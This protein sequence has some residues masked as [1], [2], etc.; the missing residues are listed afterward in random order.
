MTMLTVS[1][2]VSSSALTPNPELAAEAVIREL[3]N[4]VRQLRDFGQVDWLTLRI[5]SEP[6]G[7]TAPLSGIIV[8]MTAEGT[9]R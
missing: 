7:G 3:T 4:L 6:V 2:V 1:G 5:E 9:Q 8:T